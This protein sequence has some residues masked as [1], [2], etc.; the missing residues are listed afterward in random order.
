MID[1][2]FF[3]LVGLI[4]FFVVIVYF[5]VHKTIAKS[6]DDRADKIKN[7]LDEA[8]QLRE[9]A[10]ELLADYQR[11]RKAAEEEAGEIVA[12]AKR[13]A[14]AIAKEAEAKTAEFIERR[15]AMAEQKI[16][17][18]EADAIAQVRATAVDR[19]VAAAEALVSDKVSGATATSLFKE[20]LESIKTRMN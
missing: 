10:Q 20:S 15:T 5:G 16:E 3:A 2:T 11:K 17:Q 7:Q 9:E 12:S 1:A 19:A 18:A 4:L 6:L 14:G 8:R 13:E